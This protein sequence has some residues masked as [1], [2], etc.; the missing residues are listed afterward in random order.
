MILWQRQPPTIISLTSPSLLINNRFRKASFLVGSLGTCDYKLSSMYF[1]NFPDLLVTAV[2]YSQVMSGKLK[3][4]I[5]TTR[6]TNGKKTKL[7]KDWGVLVDKKW[8]RSELCIFEAIITFWTTFAEA[9]LPN[10]GM[11]LLLST[12]V[13]HIGSRI[14]HSDYCVSRVSSKKSALEKRRDKTMDLF[15]S[16]KNAVDIRICIKLL[17]SEGIF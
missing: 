4:P 16:S 13:T 15:Y 17:K 2:W 3:F 10:Q 9:R 11:L 6:K 14:L 7:K 8:N 12:Q 5:R 1:R